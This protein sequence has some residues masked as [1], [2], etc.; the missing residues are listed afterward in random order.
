MWFAK[1]ETHT[2]W[3]NADGHLLT[4]LTSHF[5]DLAHDARKK[6]RAGLDKTTLVGTHLKGMT[7]AVSMTHYLSKCAA[8]NQLGN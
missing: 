7:T 2:Y 6:Q 3:K 1:L 4:H 5:A 8:I